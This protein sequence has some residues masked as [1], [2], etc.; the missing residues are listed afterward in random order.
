MMESVEGNDN[1]VK[2]SETEHGHPLSAHA[3]TFEHS[4][5]S[6]CVPRAEHLQKA[7]LHW[8]YRQS[9]H[10]ISGGRLIVI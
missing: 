1:E 10:P 2:A 5:D 8:P 3:S 4:S 7:Q 9:S 6:L